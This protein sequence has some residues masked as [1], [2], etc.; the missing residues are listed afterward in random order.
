MGGDPTAYLPQRP[1]FLWIDQV[2]EV[3]RGRAR[4]QKRVTEADCQGH[5]PGAP[6][7][8]GVLVLEGMAQTASLLAPGR[9]LLAGVDGARFRLPVRPGDTVIYEAELVRQGRLG[10]ARVSAQVGGVLA[11]EATLLFAQ[12]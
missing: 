3:A 6:L 4:A 5:F 7:F 11:A 1:P 12:T 8:P 9:C 2:L 10:K